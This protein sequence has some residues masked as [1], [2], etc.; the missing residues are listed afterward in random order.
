MA[1]AMS[2][3]IAEVSSGTDGTGFSTGSFTPTANSLLTV[4]VF[5][6]GTTAAGSMS[7]G[8]LSWTKVGSA[9]YRRRLFG[10]IVKL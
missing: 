7:G 2:E 10:L 9:T 6:S 5:A 1:L 4:M 3:P 8:S